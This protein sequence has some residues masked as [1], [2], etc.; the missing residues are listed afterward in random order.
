MDVPVDVVRRHLQ[1]FQPLVVYVFGSASTGTA[2]AGSDIDI[3]FLPRRRCEPYDVFSAGGDLATELGRDVDLVDLSSA[4]TV[5][6]AE[7]LRTGRRLSTTDETRADQFEM[8]TLAD[9]A[10]LNQER[11]AAVRSFVAGF[12]REPEA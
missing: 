7:V 8:Y 12:G 2:R 9:Y 3:G 5:M 4:P 6:R 11:S 10:D 1:R